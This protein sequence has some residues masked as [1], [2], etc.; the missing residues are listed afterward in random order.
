MQLF[1]QIQILV[2]VYWSANL[3]AYV[4]ASAAV[5]EQPFAPPSASIQDMRLAQKRCDHPIYCD[6]PLLK[7]VQL[8]GV[9]DS[10]KTFVDMPTRKP[11]DKIV[12]EFGKLPAN[13]S[14]A[15]LSKFVEENFY[16]AGSD[17]VEVELEDWNEDPPFL[18]GIT[19]PVLRGYGMSLH[20]QWKTLGRKRDISFLCSGCESSLLPVK[21]TFI[22]TG[23]NSSREF[24]YWNTYY[25]EL[26]LLKSGLFKTAKGVL[27]N[28]LDAISQYGFVP[29]GGRIYYTDRTEPPLLALMVKTYFEATNDLAFVA[30]AL[31]LLK[32]EHAFWDEHRS[33]NIT[34]TRKSAGSSLDKRDDLEVVTTKTTTY[35]PNLFSTAIDTS[36]GGGSSGPYLRPESYSSDYVLAKTAES[37]PQLFSTALAT[38][39]LYAASEAGT[40]PSVQYA[41]RSVATA[42]PSLFSTALRRRSLDIP[43]DNPFAAFTKDQ[44]NVLSVANINNTIAVN[45]NSILYQVEA[46]IA[47]LTMAVNNNTETKECLGYKK[48][49]ESRRQM[50]MDLAYNPDTGLFADYHLESGKHADVWSINSLWAYWAFGDSIPAGGA[51]RALEN[52]SQLHQRFPG[53]L[54]NT[55]YNTTLSWDYPHIKPPLQHMVIKSADNSEKNLGNGYNSYSEYKGTA[56]KIAQSTIDTAFCNWY[57]TGGN[58][59]GV[60]NS[61]DYSTSNS[62]GASLGTFDIDASGNEVTTTDSSSAGGFT[63]TTGI[64]IWLLDQYKAQ[65]MMPSCPNIKLNLVNKTC[66]K[67]GVCNNVR[68]CR[69]LKRKGLSHDKRYNKRAVCKR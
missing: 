57:T 8:A 40:V 28:L 45:L 48:R 42:G 60:L 6:G 69:R 30:Q 26:G 23:D 20:N 43:S 41:N 5:E 64:T 3:V 21:N 15:Q 9:F 16:P 52:I 53:G 68:L 18:Q 27:Q 25:V 1:H 12:N 13:A 46:I 55:L 65:N 38:G 36:N 51:G 24:R 56:A 44:L 2:A 37:G 39:A 19:D 17:I 22:S 29:A 32:R 33:V 61:Y 47:N 50:L 66:K 54:P 7:A 31:P 63:W 11:V 59:P 34:Y 35:G 10:D 67:K 62:S 4:S 14:K 49:A 58:I